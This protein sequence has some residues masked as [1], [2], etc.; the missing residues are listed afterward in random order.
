[1]SFTLLAIAVT[2][3]LMWLLVVRP[4]R[5]KQTQTMTMQDNLRVG[6]EVVTAG[7]LY[8]TV[9]ALRGDDVQVEIAPGTTVR[10]ARRAIVGIEGEDA[11]TAA[12]E[13]TEALP[14]NSADAR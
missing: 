10:I 12:E 4:Q 8:G 9:E 13:E 7:G 14:P 6:D 1:M 5:R 2:L 3:T 11:G